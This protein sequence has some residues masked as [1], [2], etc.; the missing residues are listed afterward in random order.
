M[1]RQLDGN[2]FTLDVSFPHPFHPMFRYTYLPHTY[3]VYVRLSSYHSA[4]RVHRIT[5]RFQHLRLSRMRKYESNAGRE[6]PQNVND[7]CSRAR[8]WLIPLFSQVQI[9]RTHHI[10]LAKLHDHCK[11]FTKFMQSGLF[12]TKQ[13]S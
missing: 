4:I 1:F 8:R 9:L 7:C 3:S 13:S 12:A 2:V 5:S 11:L 10:T 6:S